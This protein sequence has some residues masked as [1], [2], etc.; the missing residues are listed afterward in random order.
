MPQYALVSSLG[1]FPFETAGDHSLQ[2]PVASQR[3]LSDGNDGRLSK[4]RGGLSTEAEA[5]SNISQCFLARS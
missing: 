2:W 4:E 1:P 3:V 5:C